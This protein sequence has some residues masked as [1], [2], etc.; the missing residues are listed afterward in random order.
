MIEIKTKP[1]PVYNFFTDSNEDLVC[2]FEVHT[3]K[4]GKVDGCSILSII[5]GQGDDILEWLKEDK[6]E[7]LEEAYISQV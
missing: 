5:S 2:T 4:K 6:L 3:D 1:M 7:Y